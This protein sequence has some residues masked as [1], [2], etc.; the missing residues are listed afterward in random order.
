MINNQLINPRSIVV[1]GASNDVKKPGGKILKNILDGKFEGDIFVV[2]PGDIQIQGLASHKTAE[3]LPEVDL[4]ILAIPAK[5]CPDTIEVLARQ[6]STRAFIVLSAGFS[7]AD[8]N[9]RMLEN[10]MVDAVNSVNG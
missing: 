1:V 3:D 5:F 7:E 4:A 10:R 8:E 2:N 9:G 6:K